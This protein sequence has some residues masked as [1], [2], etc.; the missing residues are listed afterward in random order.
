M[1][2]ILASLSIRLSMMHGMSTRLIV[3]VI[4]I[5]AFCFKCHTDGVRNVAHH[6][7]VD[8]EELGGGPASIIH[9]Q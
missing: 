4:S 8:E 6:V 2:F 3:I 9:M 1:P 5:S 7:D